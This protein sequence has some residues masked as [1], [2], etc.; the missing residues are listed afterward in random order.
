MTRLLFACCALAF[1]ALAAPAAQQKSSGALNVIPVQGKVDMMCSAW[2]NITVHIG[3]Y[4]VLLVDTPVPA[5]A[6]GVMEELRKLSN[7]PI[8]WIINTSSS[9]EYVAGNA[10]LVAPFTGGGRTGAPFGFVG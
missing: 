10:A 6:P 4:C 7:L 8:R 3:K 2:V 5:T 9:P 1:T